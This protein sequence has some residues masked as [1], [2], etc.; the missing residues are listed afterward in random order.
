MLL[1]DL[2]ARELTAI[3]G[4]CDSIKDAI[5]YQ[6]YGHHDEGLVPH[7]ANALKGLVIAFCH[8]E[9]LLIPLFDFSS[10]LEFEDA[11]KLIEE[12]ACN[13]LNAANDRKKQLNEVILTDSFLEGK[14]NVN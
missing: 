5:G 7:L 9:S 10:S 11:L 14:S 13:L 2:S 4:V 12:L 3:A 1:P 6:E 8:E